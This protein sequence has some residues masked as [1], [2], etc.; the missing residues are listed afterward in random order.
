MKFHKEQFELE[1]TEDAK[2]T[3]YTTGNLWN[4]WGTPSFTF[5]TAMRLMKLFNASNKES[6]GDELVYDKK[7]DQFVYWSQGEVY[8]YFKPEYIDT[9]DGRKKVYGI[10]AYCWCWFVSE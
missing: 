6:C 5:R 9:K 10:G 2:F 4:G 7:G 3:G 8:S 1:S